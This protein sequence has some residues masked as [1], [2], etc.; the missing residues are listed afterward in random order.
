MGSEPRAEG[1]LE[2]AL[3][4]QRALNLGLM[5]GKRVV[6]MVRSKYLL[7]GT[8]KSSPSK[9]WKNDWRWCRWFRSQS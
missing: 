6:A 2:R 3:L 4:E 8:G 5:E 9:V 1:L 7:K